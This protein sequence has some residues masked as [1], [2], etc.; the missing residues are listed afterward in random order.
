MARSTGC[1]T[2]AATS[3][4]VGSTPTRASSA[5][6][7]GSARRL[8]NA[9]AQDR[10]LPGA[11]SAQSRRRLLAAQEF[12]F[13]SGKRGFDS[14]RRRHISTHGGRQ[15]Y[16]ASL[17][18][19]TPPG[20]T[21][22]RGKA[23]CRRQPERSGAIPSSSLVAR[24]WFCVVWGPGP[25]PLRRRTIAALRTL[26]TGFDSRRRDRWAGATVAHESHTLGISRFNSDPSNADDPGGTRVS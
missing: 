6:A 5:P 13:S 7:D 16:E 24:V 25:K 14:P 20:D 17:G 23:R 22:K 8:L 21:R 2:R 12:R 3:R 4:W 19:S 18:G 1:A 26:R 10:H 11:P 9:G 15:V